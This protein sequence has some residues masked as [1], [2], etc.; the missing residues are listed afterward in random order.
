MSTVQYFV[1]TRF[2]LGILSTG[3][4][5]KGGGVEDVEIGKCLSDLRVVAGDSRDSLKRETF[6]PFAPD[7]HIV[8]GVISKDF[9]FWNYSFYAPCLVRVFS[10]LLNLITCSFKQSI[11]DFSRHKIPHSR[12]V[13]SGKCS[14]FQLFLIFES[15]GMPKEH[16]SDMFAHGDP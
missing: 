6:H 2:V 15:D 16:R 3:T 8:P 9:W 13:L 5:P 4:C 7:Y 14:I 1:Y 11:L 12:A 10:Y